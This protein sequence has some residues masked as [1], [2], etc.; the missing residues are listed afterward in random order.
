[1]SVHAGF[2]GQQFNPLAI[3]KLATLKSQ[4]PAHVVLEV[5]GGVNSDTIARCAEAGAELLVVGSAI[6]QQENYQIAVDQ[7]LSML[8]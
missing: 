4:K 6:F 3:Q 1:M 5:D 7:L 8:A 2:G